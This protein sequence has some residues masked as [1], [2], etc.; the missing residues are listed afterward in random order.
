MTKGFWNIS[1]SYVYV[2]VYIY[3]N[4]YFTVLS[5]FLSLPNLNH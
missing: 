5:A 2:C 1:V 4:I 3:I